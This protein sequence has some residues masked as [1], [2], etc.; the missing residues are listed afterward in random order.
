MDTE[1]SRICLMLPT[2]GRSH[3]YL[4]RFIDSAIATASSPKR[5]SFVFCVNAGD[6]STIA[7]LDER[8][9]KGHANAV[10]FESLPSPNLAVYFNMLYKSALA[11]APGAVVSM[12][13]D[14]IDRKSVV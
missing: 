4:P 5:V 13:G 11:R 8:D 2:Y 3:T 1:Y 10:V 6:N 12:V 7:Y 14:D 9:F